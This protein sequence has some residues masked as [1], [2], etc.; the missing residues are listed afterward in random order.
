VNLAAGLECNRPV[1]VKF[2]LV[3]PPLAVVQAAIRSQQQHPID[4]AAYRFR[5]HHG[6]SS[7]STGDEIAP[8]DSERHDG[9]KGD[10]E[11]DSAEEEAAKPQLND[12]GT[13]KRFVR[14]GARRIRSGVFRPQRS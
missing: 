12:T 13:D 2:Q 3:F 6:G 1:A 7:P 9:E 11:E 8:L 10:G 5:R 14:R 4:K